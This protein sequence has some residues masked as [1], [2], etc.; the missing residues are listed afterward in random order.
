MLHKK[1]LC[2]LR[3]V[4]FV[5]FLLRLD[6][7]KY[8]FK[9]QEIIWWKVVKSYTEVNTINILKIRRSYEIVRHEIYINFLA[10]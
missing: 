4:V 6:F 10:S 8:F 1:H 5:G 2:M 3:F 9:S 7:L